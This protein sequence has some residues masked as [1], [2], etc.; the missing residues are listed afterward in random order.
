MNDRGD[1]LA[2]VI[3][4]GLIGLTLGVLFAPDAGEQ[5]RTVVRDRAMDTMERVRD[6]GDR[7]REGVGRV[8][9][10]V[11]QVGGTVRERFGAADEQAATGAAPAKLEPTDEPT[12]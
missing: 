1:F 4:G 10:S 9:E 5:T 12:V 6:A 3:I 2:G 7:L 8:R 11:G